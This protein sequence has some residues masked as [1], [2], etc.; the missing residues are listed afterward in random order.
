MATN[1][2]TIPTGIILP[3]AYA[4]ALSNYLTP[5]KLSNYSSSNANTPPL[6]V[7]GSLMLPSLLA[8]II[9]SPLSPSELA[10]QMTPAVLHGY[11]RHAVRDADYP[12]VVADPPLTSTST[13]SA[14]VPPTVPSAVV[15]FLVFGL[16]PS[17][18]QHIDNFESGLYDLTAVKADIEVVVDRVGERT[19]LTELVVEEVEA[20][21]YVWGGQRD[22]L[23][24]AEGKGW[25]FE[26]FL[27]SGMGRVCE[28][29][30]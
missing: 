26:G 23:V 4:F 18:R 17:Q 8:R 16:T 3:R 20:E 25:S 11:A 24:D 13:E 1:S 6:F 19:E 12:A 29:G 2:T 15:G 5:E 22:E 30:V 28:C 10:L 14:A 21:V 27:G 9:N 7:Y